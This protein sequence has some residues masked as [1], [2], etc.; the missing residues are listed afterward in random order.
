M[1]QDSASIGRL[2]ERLLDDHDLTRF[3]RCVVVVEPERVRVRRPP[4]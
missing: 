2:V 1:S 3:E 4:R